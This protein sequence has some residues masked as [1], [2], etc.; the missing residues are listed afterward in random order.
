MHA[1]ID[2]VFIKSVAHCK[3]SKTC[4]KQTTAKTVYLYRY[5]IFYFIVDVCSVAVVLLTRN[6]GGRVDF[7]R[8]PSTKEQLENGGEDKTRKNIRIFPNV[9]HECSHWSQK[10]RQ[11]CVCIEFISFYCPCIRAVRNTY[12]YLP[13]A[14]QVTN[15]SCCV[16]VLNAYS[17]QHNL[18]II[19]FYR[20]LQCG[21]ISRA[22]CLKFILKR[23]RSPSDSVW[24]E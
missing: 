19:L 9:L 15:K 6:F 10:W 4:R 20:L 23:S 12:L 2:F 5:F 7:V 14:K 17:T 3:W 13:Y 16:C 8:G 11:L 18:Y 22:S 21:V 24:V 1:E